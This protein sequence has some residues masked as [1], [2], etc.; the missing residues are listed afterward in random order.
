MNFITTETKTNIYI[1]I[2]Y[3]KRDSFGFP[4]VNFPFLD[5][6]IPKQIANGVF[7]GELVRY[8]RACTYLKNFANRTRSLVTKLKAQFFTD[9]TLQRSWSKFCDNHILLI[10]KYG[11]H[12]LNL[13]EMWR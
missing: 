4:I 5:G 3:D 13:H 9:S 11:K 12:V 1:Y 8:A 2:I 6:N 7:I 10:H